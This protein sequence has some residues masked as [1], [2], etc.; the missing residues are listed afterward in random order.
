MTL[1]A[2]FFRSNP[3]AFIIFAALAQPPRDTTQYI[4]MGSNTQV[5]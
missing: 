3:M 5:H 4:P 2:M 1:L